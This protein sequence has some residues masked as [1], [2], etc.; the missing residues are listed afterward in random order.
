MPQASVAVSAIGTPYANLAT[1]ARHSRS[2]SRGEGRRAIKVSARPDRRPGLAPSGRFRQTD[3]DG[4]DCSPSSANAVAGMHHGG[5]FE[6]GCHAPIARHCQLDAQFVLTAWADAIR[7]VQRLNRSRNARSSGLRASPS[8]PTFADPD[9]APDT[10]RH[11]RSTMAAA[12]WGCQPQLRT[13]HDESRRMPPT[14]PPQ[15]HPVALAS[16]PSRRHDMTE[17][18]PTAAFARLAPSCR[19]PMPITSTSWPRAMPPIRPRSMPH[20]AEF[21]R[22]LGDTEMDSQAAG[23]GPVLGAR[24]LAAA[25][26][27]MT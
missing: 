4:H 26:G 18:S 2:Y 6:A 21:F 16:R 19:A 27:R 8:R 17:Q 5:S 25:A 24:R 10:Q 23:A 7:Q 12:S 1:V 20:W 11:L 22:Q 3:V 15:L 14:D 9:A 13:A